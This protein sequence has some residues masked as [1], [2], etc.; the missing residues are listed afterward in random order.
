[1]NPI[2]TGE[3][4]VTVGEALAPKTVKAAEEAAHALLGDTAIGRALTGATG[5]G[6]KL[7]KTASEEASELLSLAKAPIPSLAS[8]AAKGDH[9]IGFLSLGGG[10]PEDAAEHY[11]KML[12]VKAPEVRIQTI[13]GKGISEP[14]DLSTLLL[15][16]PAFD[17]GL[18]GGTASLETAGAKAPASGIDW[19]TH[20]V[21]KWP[22]EAKEVMAEIRRKLGGGE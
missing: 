16:H 2:K 14:E 5:A 18:R 19:G 12:G 10:F 15:D 20:G 21:V 13:T 11:S 22:P 4:I 8:A 3:A 9:S 7:A 6:E 17:G 1:M